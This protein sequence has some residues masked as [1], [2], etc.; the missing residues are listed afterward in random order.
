MFTW[1]GLLDEYNFDG[2]DVDWEYPGNEDRGGSPNDK[3]H[4][5][6]FMQELREAFDDY[7]FELTAA[8]PIVRSDL[9]AG[10]NV[11]GL[12]K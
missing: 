11:E 9:E 4:Y 2:L 12:C 10:Y 6:T 1:A 8:V 5:L 3:N 7:G